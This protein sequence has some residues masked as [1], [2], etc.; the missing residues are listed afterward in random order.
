MASD[1]NP[2]IKLI[3]EK[4]AETNKNISSI[5][6]SINTEIA[7]L[8]SGLDTHTDR[9]EKIENEL[10]SINKSN[11]INEL[12]LQIEF[13]NQD[14]LR[15]NVRLTELPPIAFDDPVDTVMSIDNV[16]Q[17]DLIPSDFTAYADRHK[18]SLIVSFA[19]YAH[20][21]LLIN[22]LQQRKAL[23]VEEIFPSIKSNS[24]IYVNDQLTPHFAKIFQSAW[25]A[26][27]NGVIFSA[28]SVGGRIKIKLQEMSQAIII[29]TEEQL[30]DLL[31][32]SK[33]NDIST[34]PENGQLDQRSI[35]NG[36]SD[37]KDTDQGARNT[38][39]KTSTTTKKTEPYSSA[40]LPQK[41]S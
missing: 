30:Q 8:R 20:K 32:G 18:S 23:L 16:L 2:L 39:S 5:Q 4:F 24:N 11:E 36:N 41:S 38:H 1:D 7:N 35:F 6:S 26:K 12:Q 17:L 3:E 27:K 13:L 25:Q 15:N 33:S 9:I 29:E 21:R 19:S 28:S 22:L 14:R 10:Q 31:N 40:V 34:E 37:N